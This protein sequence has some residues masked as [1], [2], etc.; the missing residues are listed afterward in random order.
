VGCR[1]L[2]KGRRTPASSIWPLSG[3]RPRCVQPARGRCGMETRLRGR[4]LAL[5][6]LDIAVVQYM[7]DAYDNA[8][9][10]CLFA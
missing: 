1:T 5:T 4:E 7:G 8:L 6:A 2:R 9:C 3:P 10:E